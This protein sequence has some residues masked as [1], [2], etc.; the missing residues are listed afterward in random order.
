LEQAIQDAPYLRALNKEGMV[1]Y[2][3]DLMSELTPGLLKGATRQQQERMRQL[4]EPWTHLLEEINLR[5]MSMREFTPMLRRLGEAVKAGER[6]DTGNA[7]TIPAGG[8]YQVGRNDP[9]PC[10]SN[11]KFKKCCDPNSVRNQSVS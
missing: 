10:G 7:P 11:K 1:Q 4:M 6:T 3:K 2:A 5:G 9:C 8:K